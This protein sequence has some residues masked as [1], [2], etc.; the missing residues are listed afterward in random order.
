M[1]RLIVMVVYTILIEELASTRIADPVR[2][3][4]FRVIHVLGNSFECWKTLV[5]RMAFPISHVESGDSHL[6]PVFE[7]Q[8]RGRVWRMGECTGEK[9][10]AVDVSF[11]SFFLVL[12]VHGKIK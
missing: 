5:A 11:S 1:S 3:P 2:I 4:V 8:S 6:L 9:Q 10:R 12:W 7:V